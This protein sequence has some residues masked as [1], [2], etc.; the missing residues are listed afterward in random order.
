MNW[1]TKTPLRR[2]DCDLP[3]MWVVSCLDLPRIYSTWA[4]KEFLHPWVTRPGDNVCILE[5]PD[6]VNECLHPWITRSSENNCFYYLFGLTCL[7]IKK[8]FRN[9][10]PIN[11]I[12]Q[13]F[14]HFVRNAWHHHVTTEF[15]FWDV[16]WSLSINIFSLYKKLYCCG[17]VHATL[18]NVKYRR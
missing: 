17:H 16:E 15:S 9:L 1:K 7:P 11:M 10:G 13:K 3:N 4:G 5:S 8:T 6:Q 12:S 14:K 18:L 2:Q